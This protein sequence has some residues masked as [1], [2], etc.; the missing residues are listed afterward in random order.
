MS[1]LAAIERD[2]RHGAMDTDDPRLVEGRHLFSA[3]SGTHLTHVVRMSPFTH[4]ESL[5]HAPAWDREGVLL[6]A[7]T[8]RWPV[9]VFR[10][11]ADPQ[12]AVLTRI[13]TGEAG[14]LHAAERRD[15]R[16][17]RGRWPPARSP[18]R[19]TRERRRPHEAPTRS[20]RK[21]SPRESTARR[22]LERPV[23]IPLG[24]WTARSPAPSDASSSPCKRPSRTARGA[25]SACCAWGS[26]RQ[27]STHVTEPH[28]GRGG[29]DRS[30]TASSSASA[31]GGLVTRVAPTDR[32]SRPAPRATTRSPLLAPTSLPLR[33]RRSPQ[34]RR[35]CAACRAIG[36]DASRHA[37]RRGRD[38]PWS[39]VPRASRG[40]RT[41][42]SASSSPSRTTRATSK[43]SATAS[44]SPTSA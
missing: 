8:G 37:R 43:S 24:S 29:P 28:A 14:A 44:S 25:S 20:R 3:V 5:G 15:P 7:P 33:D 16:A 32:C 6:V 40:R 41:G 27:R 30:P 11:S 35:R 1:T 19:P 12:S 42:S 21:R 4:A 26:S 22:F 2:A 9:S 31:A 18:A 10:A 23:A 34:S 17:R 39:Q 13:V 36:P 38:G